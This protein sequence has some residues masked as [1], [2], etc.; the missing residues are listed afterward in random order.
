MA[1][2]IKFKRGVGTPSGLTLGE[3]AYDLSNNKLFIGLTSSSMWVGAEVD[4]GDLT[5]NSQIKIPTQYAVKQYVDGFVGGGAVTTVNG[6]TGAVNIVGG[7]SINV[8]TVGKTFTIDNQGVRSIS[9]TS[10]QIS[11]SGATGDITISIPSSLTVPGSLNVSTDLTVSGNLTI[12]G[13]TTTVN[14]NVSTIDDPILLIGTS[15]G[16]PISA[17]DG[18][19]DR[20][21]AFTYYDGAAG[22]TGFFGFDSSTSKFTYIPIATVDSEIITSGTP[23]DVQFKSLY[24]TTDGTNLGGLTL[25]NLA[26]SRT[27]TLPDH[28]GTIVAPSDLGTNNYILKA[29]GVTLQ[30]TWADQSTL[31]VGSAATLT[32]ARTIGITGDIDG[33]A[34]SFD[35]STNI[36]ISAT[37][38]ANSVALGT[39]TTGNYVSTI[40]SS[41]TGLSV[42]NSGTE[43]AAV[44]IDFTTITSGLNMG[45]FTF[46]TSEFINTSGT[47]SLGVIDGG[48]Y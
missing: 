42:Q 15:G 11:V 3:P 29:S 43:T 13:T 33:V 38:A 31:S 40:S 45:T 35:G 20:G 34:T 47:I 26:S 48:F 16:V 41:S 44:T 37:I 14:S 8:T 27:Y 2:N 1:S 25:A 39:D 17:S 22:R 28:T 12:N 4:N 23:G 21:I 24:L 18:G 7:S 9:G 36:T 6:A 19:K 32:T 30:P 5:T 10:N 46:A